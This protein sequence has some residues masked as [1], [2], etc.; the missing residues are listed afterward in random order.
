MISK[1][2]RR[3]G[4][5]AGIALLPAMAF[6]SAANAATTDAPQ[7]PAAQQQAQHPHEG[8]HHRHK[9]QHV[10]L[11]GTITKVG[12]K[13]VRGHDVQL[14]TVAGKAKDGKQQEITFAVPKK[15][16][17]RDEAGKPVA[18]DQ[19]TQGK[20]VTVKGMQLPEKHEGVAHRIT[21]NA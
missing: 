13:K 18:A 19:L 7:Q 3:A 6:G 15:A 5:V 21:I 9:G 12:T 8:Q 4:L 14:I 11:T 2:A 20:K 1:T 17:V 10:E 16:T